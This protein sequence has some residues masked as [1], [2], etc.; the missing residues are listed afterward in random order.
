MI[1]LVRTMLRE[2]EVPLP[3]VIAMVS[4][5]PAREAGLASK[6]EIAVGKDADLVVLSPELEVLQTYVAGVLSFR[7]ESRN[8]AAK[9]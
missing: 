7:A 2:A 3:E 9:A 4:V 1:D 6:G 5:N 8:P